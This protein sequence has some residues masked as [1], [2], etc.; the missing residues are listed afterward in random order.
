M[1]VTPEVSA[2]MA[3]KQHRY[4]LR[5]L[6]K[7]EL[8]LLRNLMER[9]RVPFDLEEELSEE[10]ERRVALCS[11]ADSGWMRKASKTPS[12]PSSSR[13]EFKREQEPKEVAK[14]KDKEPEELKE[15]A[16][17][18]EASASAAMRSPTRSQTEEGRDQSA[19]CEA[20]EARSRPDTGAE[21][22]ETE[23]SQPNSTGR[24]GA[25]FA[26]AF[27]QTLLLAGTAKAYCLDVFRQGQPAQWPAASEAPAPARGVCGYRPGPLKRFGLSSPWA[28]SSFQVCLFLRLPCRSGL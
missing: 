9:H 16:E 22:A 13:S 8:P 14:P 2:A 18:K 21:R 26:S 12:M 6:E 15:S 28:L 3:E 11:F 7:L 24:G 20:S 17:S 5:D 25:V 1:E 27:S 19:A 4:D 10:D 23:E